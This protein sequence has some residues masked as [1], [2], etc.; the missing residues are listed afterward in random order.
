MPSTNPSDDVKDDGLQVNW[1]DC[2][3][4]SSSRADSLELADHLSGNPKP[5]PHPCRNVG[6]GVEGS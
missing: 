6:G 5:R 1:P 2:L 4:A 3:P